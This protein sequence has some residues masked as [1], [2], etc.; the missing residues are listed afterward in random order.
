MA[1]VLGVSTSGYYAWLTRPQSAKEKSDAA[2]VER[3]QAIHKRSRRTYGAPRIQA[4][5][6]DDGV[7]VSR[8]GSPD[9][10]ESP[11]CRALA[12]ASGR[13]PPAAPLRRVRRRTLSTGSLRQRRRTGFGWPTSPTCRRYRASPSWPSS[14]TCSIGESSAGQWIR[15]SRATSW[16]ARWRWRSPS[17]GRR[18]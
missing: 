18:R 15:L 6:A 9:S 7:P 14:L 2:L 1:C 4:E 11:A 10:C 8:S 17:A 16:S 12:G 5:L 13:R 3:M